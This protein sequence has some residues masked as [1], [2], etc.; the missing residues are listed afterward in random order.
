MENKLKPNVFANMLNP[1]DPATVALVDQ[2][3]K[4][5]TDRINRMTPAERTRAMMVDEASVLQLYDVITAGGGTLYGFTKSKE[6]RE[7][8]AVFVTKLTTKLQAV[9]EE[10]FTAE[11]PDRDCGE[12]SAAVRAFFFAYFGATAGISALEYIALIGGEGG[13]GSDIRASAFHMVVGA[14][15]SEISS[16]MYAMR[17]GEVDSVNDVRSKAEGAA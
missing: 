12:R 3:A 5:Q 6:E 1:A 4:E 15:I 11:F 7:A 10:A 14:R 17:G 13:L 8:R 16:A 9:A 2:R